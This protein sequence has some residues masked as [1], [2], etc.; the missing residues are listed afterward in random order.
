M[1]SA[2]LEQTDR[3]EAVDDKSF[4]LVLKRP[5][6]FVIDALGKID[7]NVPFMMPER[8]AKTDP[9][10]QITEVIGSGP[11]R[12]VKNEWVPGHKVVYEKFADY[13]PR[14]EPPSQAA[15][16]KLVKIDRVELIL[17][18]RSLG[19]DQR[20]DQGRGRSARDRGERSAG[21]GS[22]PRPPWSSRRTIPLGYQLFMMINHLH[23]PFD[24]KAARQALLRGVKQSE[25]L[26][27][28]I[29]DAKR[30]EECT[31]LFGCG[32]PITRAM[33][34]PRV[35]RSSIRP[36]PRRCCWR[37]AMTEGRS[38]SST[39]P[40]TPPCT[41]RALMARETLV[42]MGAAVDL[43]ALDWSTVLQRARP[44]RRPAKAAG[45]SWSPTRR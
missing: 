33:P 10:T 30:W 34:E 17:H 13:R 36:R 6:G 15:G 23:P 35:S 24:K 4:R 38:Q 7:S 20:A 26:E 16:G 8:L 5:L 21:A 19:R 9:N 40:T 2:L 31:A 44:R 18:A 43:V 22:R 37:R 29:G 12:F 45:T 28:A 1:G 3:L 39:R 42:R 11:F 25:F 27:S 32:T 14:A 41:A